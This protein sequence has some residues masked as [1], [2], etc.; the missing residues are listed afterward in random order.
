MSTQSCERPV[1]DALAAMTAES[2]ARCELDANSLLAARIAASAAVDA[3][4]ASYLMHVVPSMDEGVT[5]EQIQNILTAVADRRHAADA[6]RRPISPRRWGSSSPCST[7]R[8]SKP[9]R[10]RDSAPAGVI[11]VTG[12]GAPM[13]RTFTHHDPKHR[14]HRAVLALLALLIG[15]ALLAGCGS[16]SSSS[17]P[18]YCDAVTKMEN[19]VKSLPTVRDVKTNGVGTFKSAVAQLQQNATTALNQATAPKSAVDALSST[20]KQI[21]STPSVQTLAQ[22][23]AQLSAVGTAAKNLQSAV[24]SKCG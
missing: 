19:A 22:L 1:L 4:A 17:K 14:R 6:G 10:T 23:P 16:N 15:G 18:A 2:A 11:A 3:P 21:A 9:R 13:T 12:C 20:A 24:S 8:S 7:G 5:V